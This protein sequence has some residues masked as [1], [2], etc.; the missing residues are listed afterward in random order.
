M[1]K[2]TTL[3]PGS[4]SP[5]SHH[6]NNVITQPEHFPAA[7]VV[8]WNMKILDGIFCSLSREHF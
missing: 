4:I 6:Q 5:A 8:T 1:K 3:D 7:I 2:I